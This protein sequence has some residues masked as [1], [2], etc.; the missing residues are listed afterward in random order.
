[1]N[2]HTATCLA[3]ALLLYAGSADAQEV[4]SVPPG[5]DQIVPMKKGEPAP[6]EGQ[7]FDNNTALRWG[8]WLLQYKALVKNNHDLDQKICTADVDLQHKKIELL[9]RQYDQV[10]GELQAK[11]TVA[12]TELANP[13]WYRT[14]PFGIVVG[15]VAT[16]AVG[17]STAVL[18]NSVK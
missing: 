14:V 2:T 15:V 10:T 17:L 6:F 7:L 11:L 13:P 16:V 9:Q 8:N 5:N 4:T 1:M 12:Q 3:T 18:V